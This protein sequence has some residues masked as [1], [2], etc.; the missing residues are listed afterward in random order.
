ME[1]TLEQKTRPDWEMYF[2]YMA[3][4]AAERSTCLRRKVGAVAVKDHRV[5]ATGYNGAP[6]GIE[7]CL[8]R[9]YC[10]REEQGIPSGQRH[11][12]CRGLHAEQNLIIQAAYEGTSIASSSIY[13][14]TFPCFICS[15]MLV[16]VGIKELIYL[17]GYNDPMTRDLL[18]QAE[19]PYRKID[20]PEL[21][22][23]ND[24]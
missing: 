3:M 20:V 19:I 17:T 13:C 2:S 22:L 12:I 4:L 8:Q 11:E 21:T 15:K 5:L 18:E 24:F 6:S 7:D 1:A 9:N 16:N 10:E 23:K 14:T